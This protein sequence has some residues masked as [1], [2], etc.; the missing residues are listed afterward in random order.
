MEEGLSALLVGHWHALVQ[1]DQNPSL[2]IDGHGRLLAVSTRLAHA[3][4]HAVDDMIGQPALAF[5]HP[6]DRERTRLDWD[7]R[8]ATG[9]DSQGFESRWRR[10]GG[11]ERWLSWYATGESSSGHVYAV[12]SDVTDRKRRELLLRETES[13]A[14]IG[15]WELDLVTNELYWTEETYRLHD[16]SPEG[17]TPNVASAVQFYAD[18]SQE[19]IAAA[20]AELSAHGT[21]YD[22]QLEL[23]TAKGRR[24]Q[25]RAKGQAVLENGKAVRMYGVFQDISAE[26]K[27]ERALRESEEL[28]R[29]VLSDMRAGLVG[30]GPDGAII[31]CNQAALD[32]LGLSEDEI[33]GRT[34]VDQRWYSIHEDGSPF[35]GDTHP[36]MESLRTGE[37]L[38]GVIMGVYRPTTQ[39]RAWILID[40]VVQRNEHGGVLRVLT[41]FIDITERKRAEDAARASDAMF[42]AVYQ[43]A[44]L[45]VLLRDAKT[46]AIDCNPTFER[47]IGRT[48]QEL[49]SLTMTDLVH[50]EDVAASLDAHSD[51]LAGRV[52]SYELE[53]R[54]I[55]A[56]GELVWGHE[57]V[58]L[59]RGPDGAPRY[60]VE[61]IMD[62][63][64]RKRM[65]TQLQVAKDRAESANRAK[66][67]FLSNMS[68]EIRT[69][70]NAIL[71]FA[72]ILREHDE[73]PRR[74]RHL[75]AIRTSGH[76]LLNLINDVLDLSKIE[77]GKMDLRLGAASIRTLFE[78]M[79]IVFN[80][81][82]MDKGLELLAEIEGDVPTA[83]ILDESRIRQVLMN[84]IGNAIK[85]TDDG[86]IRLAAIRKRS[87]SGH[88]GRVDL[89]LEVT[90]TGIGIPEDQQRRI[91]E[92]FMQR[93]GQ[94]ATRYGGTG[95]GLA[96]ASRLTEMMGGTIS[97]ESKPGRGSTFRVSLRGIEVAATDALPV[98]EDQRWSFQ[99]LRFEPATILIV[100]DIAYNCEV[101]TIFLEPFGFHVIQ[102]SNGREAI[103]SAREHR[104]DLILLDM[105]MP[106]VDGLEALR[107]LRE[108]PK[109]AEIPVIAVTASAL[110]QDED[111]IAK[112]CDGYLR[113]PVSKA[114]LIAEI[115]RFLPH[116]VT[117]DA[118]EERGGA[119]GREPVAS[120]DVLVRELAAMPAERRARLVAEAEAA[121][122]STLE[123]HLE[124]LGPEL[125]A[126]V[127]AIRPHLASFR[128]DLIVQLLTKGSSR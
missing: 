67:E 110:K 46:D 37:S 12:A 94:Q 5:V 113:K 101:L 30:Q 49:R 124:E 14:R 97:V 29:S 58:S 84:L 108:D 111:V 54:F 114:D 40:S 44:G 22:V 106:E 6:D 25:C 78:E 7:E 11:S 26:V 96:I 117:G 73:D 19:R 98:R 15:G 38:M 70:M 90:D 89:D 43:N 36:A 53:R 56:D 24:I 45:G 120:A 85:F 4:G 32:I 50:P 102:A 41:S 119:G 2:L 83:L 95:L 128:F 10:K 100:D 18:D 62:I 66:S 47:M 122:L 75:E 1:R 42:R 107:I 123:H 80:Q 28:L 74:S 9:T 82:I 34:S 17:Y 126:L 121:D 86:F 72:E 51:L 116:S 48:S 87:G 77:A 109:L 76:A 115:M 33:M 57:T 8:R 13:V 21:P 52:E 125:P 112:Q 88:E 99:A 27:I 127:A 20:I 60:V 35:P 61:M 59:V 23:N 3:L 68:H 39:D 63:T 104:P 71:G 65:E 31:F 105:K 92:A 118:V 103:E 81:K 64:D 79:Q 16:T 69:P 93:A 91:F 55:R